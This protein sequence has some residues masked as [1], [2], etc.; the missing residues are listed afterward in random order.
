MYAE[1]SLKDTRTGTSLVTRYRL[2]VS[3]LNRK[4]R[5]YEKQSTIL[6]KYRITFESNQEINKLFITHNQQRPHATLA[7]WLI[8]EHRE[9]W[10]K[11]LKQY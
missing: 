9:G 3:Y 5:V 7:Q 4:S 1:N 2:K 10:H 6:R 11:H 8:K